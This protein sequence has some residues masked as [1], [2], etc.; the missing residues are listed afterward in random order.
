MNR[1]EKI[2]WNRLSSFFKLPYWKDLHVRHC[3]DVMH[4]EK[5]VCMNILGTLLDI[6]GKSKDGLNARRD[7]VDLKLRPEL[8]P[9]SSENEIFIPPACY[10]LTKEEK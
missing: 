8:A 6:P 4:I 2:C 3:L 10:T 9:I 1:S 7:L 5:N